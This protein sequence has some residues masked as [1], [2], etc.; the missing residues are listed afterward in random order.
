MYNW[1]E[2]NVSKANSSRSALRFPHLP[3]QFGEDPTKI[4]MHNPPIGVSN[5]IIAAMTIESWVALI[6]DR[7]IAAWRKPATP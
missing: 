2:E 5:A 6:A 4:L 3:N 7:I 1:S